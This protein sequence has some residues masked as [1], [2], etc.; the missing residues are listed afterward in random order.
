MTSEECSNATDGCTTCD[1]TTSTCLVPAVDDRIVAC[2]S[3]ELTL[4]TAINNGETSIKICSGSTLDI[5]SEIVI[6]GSGVEIEC[7]EE[8]TCTM[9]QT[10]KE[11]FFTFSS[12]G[13]TVFGIRFE[14]G[15]VSGQDGGALRMYGTNNTVVYCD[16]VNN[17]A[18]G[19]RG[20]AIYMSDGVLLSNHYAGNAAAQC[21][22][23]FVGSTC[24]SA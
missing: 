15:F 12:G 5:S 16:F 13:G 23:V 2:I 10:V 17:A 19:G 11:R 4:N 3:D 8:G 6:T 1:T 18:E 9:R 14:S 22:D 24:S 21:S 20:G 7:I